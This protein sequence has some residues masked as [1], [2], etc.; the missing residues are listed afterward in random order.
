LGGSGIAS[1][2]VR[3]RMVMVMVSR[4][5]GMVGMVRVKDS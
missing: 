4:M 5:V 3:V 2:W 1:I